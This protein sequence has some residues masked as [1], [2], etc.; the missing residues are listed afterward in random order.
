MNLS[1]VRSMNVKRLARTED[2]MS[3]VSFKTDPAVYDLVTERHADGFDL[4][5]RDLETGD[6][7]VIALDKMV[8]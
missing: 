2:I 3:V 8:T 5:S 7:D 4:I 1:T 6:Q